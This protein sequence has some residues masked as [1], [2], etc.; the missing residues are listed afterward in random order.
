ME[1]E[2]YQNF[3]TRHVHVHIFEERG[4]KRFYGKPMELVLIPEPP[5][6]DQIPSTLVL[7]RRNMFEFAE[8]LF[9]ALRKM[10]MEPAEEA[11]MADLLEARTE[12]LERAQK[13]V[14]SLMDEFFK[15]SDVMSRIAEK[16]K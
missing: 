15:M 13:Q 9:L 7:P 6:G 4:R 8:K 2:A 16:R 11:R 12:T 1:V 3:D 5:E 10:G 14:S